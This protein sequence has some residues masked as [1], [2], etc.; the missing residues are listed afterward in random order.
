MEKKRTVEHDKEKIESTICELDEKKKEVVLTT[1][2][3]VN[4]DFGSIFSTLLPGTRACLEPAEEGNVFAGVEV[5]VA[6]GD[7][8]KESLTELSGGQRSVEFFSNLP[9]VC[10]SFFGW[11]G[12]LC[13]S[14]SALC[15]GTHVSSVFLFCFVLGDQVSLGPLPHPLVPAIQARACVHFG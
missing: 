6:F 7:T 9:S 13:L 12:V 4:R 5:R 10:L 15:C 3:K 11:D 1:F 8:W 2:E 14:C